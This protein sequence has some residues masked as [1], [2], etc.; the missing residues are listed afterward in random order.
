[1]QLFQSFDNWARAFSLL[2]DDPTELNWRIARE[3]EITNIRLTGESTTGH[4]ETL[5]H[6]IE[7]E[8]DERFYR[9]IG[10]GDIFSGYQLI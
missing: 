9:S 3:L 7:Q 5:L 2:E 1:M 8:K 4:M 6:T 10:Q